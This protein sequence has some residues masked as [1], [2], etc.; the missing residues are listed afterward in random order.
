MQE[1]NKRLYFKAQEGA[2]SDQQGSTRINKEAPESRAKHT[3]SKEKRN[4]HTEA[5]KVTTSRNNSNAG[6]HEVALSLIIIHH[7][8]GQSGNTKKSGSATQDNPLRPQG[9]KKVEVMEV[10]DA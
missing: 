3:S 6:Q 2:T 4:K 10:H 9:Q 5:E 1:E 8:P 7:H